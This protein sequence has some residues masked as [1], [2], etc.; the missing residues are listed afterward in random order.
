[1]RYMSRTEI[2]QNQLVLD[3]VRKYGSITPDEARVYCRKCTRLAP[4]VAEVNGRLLGWTEHH[5]INEKKSGYARY[6][7]ETDEE[8]DDRLNG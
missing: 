8:R 2:P 4:R 7:F 3:Y 1:M 6:R 5:L